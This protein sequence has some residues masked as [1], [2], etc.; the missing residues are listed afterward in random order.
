MMLSRHADTLV[1]AGRYLERA[2]ATTRMLAVTNTSHLEHR[3][4][5]ALWRDLLEVLYLGGVFADRHA[6]GRVPVPV[7][8]HFLVVDRENPGSVAS[9]VGRARSNL[10]HV[11]DLIPE[12]LLAAVNTLHLLL[13]DPITV[14]RVQRTPWDVYSAII[15]HSYTIA[16]I[17]EEAMS[18][19]TGYYFLTAGRSLEQAEMTCRLIDVRRT[20][21]A[22][23]S[24]AVA[25][26]ASWSDVLGAVAG[27][28]SFLHRYGAIAS[29]D[30]VVGY[31]L[32]A[33]DLPGGVLS[34]LTRAEAALAASSVDGGRAP[35]VLGRVRSFLAF[36][37]IPP[38]ESGA[39]GGLLD[40]IQV[41]IREAADALY[42][43]I[44]SANVDP[45]LSSYEAV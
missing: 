35:R 15:V 17:I 25:S 2:A 38:L 12:D 13:A 29:P 11:R 40:T 36:A 44:F 37:E 24:V 18:R 7:V 6:D 4:S 34:A 43:D 3:S 1:W 41:G 8:N 23:S 31:L 16:G 30:Q 28:Q 10:L 14:R 26:T 39:F 33:T 21:T 32:S 20:S 27:L 9:A 19:S 45:N 5:E 22:G 42:R